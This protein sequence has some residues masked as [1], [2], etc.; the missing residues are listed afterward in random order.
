MAEYKDYDFK[1]DYIPHHHKYLLFP[2]VS[3]LDK[4]N[5]KCILDLGCGNGFYA[6]KLI[7]K[8]F[9]VY[10]T[11]ASATGI[12]QIKKKYPDRFFVQ[13]LDDNDLPVEL[14]QHQFDTIVLTEVIEH[15]YDPEQF[16][17]FCHDILSRNGG[18][19][20]IITTPYNGYLKNVAIS[21]ADKWD[22]HLNPLWLGGH[23]KFWSRKTLTMALSK[24]GFSVS[25]F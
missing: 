20:L 10:G 24:T 11:D 1:Q 8:G 3:Q 13:N 25:K 23:I 12:A 18:G 19:E 22:H 14:R 16:L 5:N 2:L 15:L 7:E 6:S 17:N 9:N 4:Q 21:F